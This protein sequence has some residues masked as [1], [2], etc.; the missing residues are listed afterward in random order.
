LH[1]EIYD[2]EFAYENPDFTC[3]D[4]AGTEHSP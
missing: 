4:D 2:P 1:L 3:L